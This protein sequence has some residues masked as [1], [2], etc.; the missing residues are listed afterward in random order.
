MRRPIAPTAVVLVPAAFP[1]VAGPD[2]V[3]GFEPM[4]T[5]PGAAGRWDAFADVN[6][7]DGH[8]VE[9]S[10]GEPDRGSPG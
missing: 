2:R 5:G 4:Q 1:A 9:Q 7:T 10:G 3:P 6:G 8:A